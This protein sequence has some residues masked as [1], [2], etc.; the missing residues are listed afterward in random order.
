[1]SRFKTAECNG[2]IQMSDVSVLDNSWKCSDANNGYIKTDNNCPGAS[3]GPLLGTTAVP[4]V[5]QVSGSGARTM[6][7]PGRKKPSR[8]RCLL[9]TVFA[10]LLIS[11]VCLFL[12]ANNGQKECLKNAGTYL[13]A[14]ILMETRV[15]IT[16]HET[17]VLGKRLRE[18]RRLLA[19][20]KC[21]SGTEYLD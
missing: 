20:T 2:P 19:C 13:C 15:R 17:R 5:V 7:L 10:L 6:V 4:T 3:M 12:L 1:M 11:V 21:V 8:E 16:R 9:I 18:T 14:P